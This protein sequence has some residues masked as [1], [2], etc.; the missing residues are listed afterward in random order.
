MVTLG[1]LAS[2]VEV[3]C[4]IEGAD[5]RGQFTYLRY[6]HASG[7]LGK[8]I[9][10]SAFLLTFRGRHK[11]IGA[12]LL[13]CVDF[14]VSL[15]SEFGGRVARKLRSWISNLLGGALVARCT[16]RA[17]QRESLCAGFAAGT[18][19][20]TPQSADFRG[21]GSSLST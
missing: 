3:G 16:A 14:M 9:F 12:S 11:E 18:A 4:L 15:Y 8:C 21:R 13:R 5:M 2:D 7:D 19:H 17:G 10:D 1:V 6:S 20:C